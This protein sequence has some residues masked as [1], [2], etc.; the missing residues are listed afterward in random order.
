VRRLVCAC[1]CELLRKGDHFSIF[2]RLNHLVGFLESP[3]SL[4][5][6]AAARLGA[7]ECVAVL[8]T[9]HGRHAAKPLADTVDACRR[10]WKGGKGEPTNSRVRA[11]ALRTMAAVLVGTGGALPPAVRFLALQPSL[12]H[13][14][15]GTR[16]ARSA[17][18]EEPRTDYWQ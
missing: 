8:A 6:P 1:V 11:A 18:G 16:R 5:A 13:V 14:S 17:R 4:A 15:K 2:A 12:P 7:L 9:T 3:A 10:H